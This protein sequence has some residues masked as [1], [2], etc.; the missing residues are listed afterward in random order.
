MRHLRLPP[1]HVALLALCASVLVGGSCSFSS[2]TSDDEDED[3]GGVIIVTEE[4]QFGGWQLAGPLA[5]HDGVVSVKRGWDGDGPFFGEL[6][7]RWTGHRRVTRVSFDPDR[8]GLPELLGLARTARAEAERVTF[9][10]QSSTQQKAAREAW[11]EGSPRLVMR[12]A[13]TFHAD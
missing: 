13:A 12:R 2:K 11:P 6:F 8:I 10:A 4:A 5:G 1:L 3:Q 7:V 9:Y